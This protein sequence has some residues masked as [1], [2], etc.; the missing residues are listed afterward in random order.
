MPTHGLPMAAISASSV[1]DH[2]DDVEI[3]EVHVTDVVSKV[4]TTPLSGARNGA[5]HT[6][7]VT[8]SD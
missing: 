4:R 8:L 7:T 3:I 2:Y 5:H 6:T 1:S